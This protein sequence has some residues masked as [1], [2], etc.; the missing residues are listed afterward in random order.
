MR[1]SQL[2]SIRTGVA[3]AGT[4]LSV[5][6]LN[7]QEVPGEPVMVQNRQT[8]S[9]ARCVLLEVFINNVSMKMIGTF[10]QQPDGSLT[11]TAEELRQVGIKPPAG[12]A[13]D[14]PVKLNDLDD[15]S[16]RIDE[17]AQRLYVTTS[18][19]GRTPRLIDLGQKQKGD[20]PEPRSGSGGVLNYSLFASSRTL[21]E[22]DANIFQGISGSFDA[23]IFSP[24]GTLSQ[25]FL[26]GYSDGELDRVTRLNTTWSY[27]DPH[28]L[29]SYRMGDVTTGGLSW[30]RPVYLGGLQVQRNFSLRSDLVTEPLP[31]FEG[32][33][34]VPSTL[35]IYSQNV[36]NYTGDVPAGPFQVTNFPTFSGLG[37]ARIVLRDSLGR[38]TTETLPFYS[39]N[40]LLRAG[41]FDFSVEAGAPRRNFGIRSDDYDERVMGVATARYGLTDW[42]TLE[43]HLE[44]GEELFNGGIGT[45]F[46][47]GAWG[48]A[49]VAV[50]GS[51]SDAGSGGLVN[52]SLELSYG[53]WSIY[54]RMQRALHNYSDIASVTAAPAQNNA[55]D[56]PAFG[57]GVPRA[58][59]QVTVS[60]PAPLDLS[61]LNFSYTRLESADGE[62]HRI[63]G[64][65]YS[66]TFKR[67]TFY[68]SAFADI[69]DND[70][71]GIFAGVSVPFDGNISANTGI[72]S[73]P[74]G[75]N[76]IADVSK[77]EQQENGSV[78]WRAR[79]SEGKVS[80]REAAVSYRAPFA[81][82]EGGVQQYGGDVRAT[83]Q[84]DGAVVI[85]GGD[86]F[87]TNRIDD[88]FAIVDVGTPGVEVQ[89]QNR[90]VG[91]TDSRGRILVP[92]L[93]SYEPNTV[94][95]DP[96]NLPV[97]ADVPATRD[98]VVPADRSGV[99]VRFGVSDA[100]HAAIVTIKDESGRPLP[101]GLRGK[102][103]HGSDE[104]VIGYDGHAYIRNLRPKNTIDV[105]LPGGGACGAE[106]SYT[107]Q[108]GKQIV[109]NDVRCM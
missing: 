106:F 73:G 4:I 34:A 94:S 100:P 109:V 61:S 49:S 92:D 32:T 11:A 103:Q 63:A 70:S 14:A 108:P 74:D 84:M 79:T 83:A 7:A 47:V 105:M 5:S 41:L 66:Q 21:F 22:D 23:R 75:I 90:P 37:E 50:A 102:L 60:A 62:E 53:D 13:D 6:A 85:A 98:V 91:K 59:D 18:D 86:V 17:E 26:A 99:V 89:L 46:P 81:R 80:N 8:H 56:T 93:N 20:V 101:A 69:E 19:D 12:A 104:F 42:L 36:R 44:G 39:S 15:L 29:L 82:F 28:R 43:S 2:A 76:V 88:A 52:A 31:A 25:S 57:A 35:E 48:V 87:A 9:N 40:L 45:A 33:A 78:G 54:A 38:E 107:P 95:V 55:G 1:I 64:V 77:S 96:K 16:F 10:R 72:E 68:A 24:Y 65:S 71:F 30:T 67:A 97:D 3:V 58:L 27:S 51:K